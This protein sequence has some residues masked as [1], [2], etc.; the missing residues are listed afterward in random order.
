M[1]TTGEKPYF[2]RVTPSDLPEGWDRVKLSTI[3]SFQNGSGLTSNN[4]QEGSVPVYG[5]N[6]IVGHHNEANSS[7][8]VIIIGRKGSAGAVNYSTTPTFVIDTAYYADENS[9][10]CNLK[11]LYYVLQSLELEG[12]SEDS[13]VPGM[14]RKFIGS[15]IVPFPNQ[16]TQEIITE[17]L[18]R[19]TRKMDSLINK[20]SEMVKLIDERQQAVN[21]RT[22]ID[23]TGEQ[24]KIS[25]DILKVIKHRPKNWEVRRAK[26]LFTE[27]DDRGYDNLP[28]LEVSLNHGV[29]LREENKDRKAWVASDLTKMKRVCE[30]DLVFNKM[31]LWQ[32]AIGR[33]DYEG[34]VSPDY[35]VLK[36]HSDANPYYYNQLLRTEAYKTEVNRRSYGVVDDRMRIYWKQFGD[37]PLLHPSL[38]EQENIVSKLQRSKDRTD[39]LR[40]DIE[41]SIELLKEKR[42]AL[43]VRAITGQ[44]NIPETRSLETETV[45]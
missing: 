38:E 1:T 27:R 6:G 24:E 31:R 45:S 12:Q 5:S 32:G 13:A 9:S 25:D 26:T 2:S 8:P 16:D 18:D 20:N 7:A 44:I 36:P 37:I 21:E 19:Q 40:S 4:R 28:L 33:S 22:T 15:H 10:H 41:S 30:N 39:E 42:Q 29:R 11:W 43:I 3:C 35:T 14:N 34:L 17:F 23:G